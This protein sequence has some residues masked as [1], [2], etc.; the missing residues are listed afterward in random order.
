MLPSFFETMILS[1][2]DKFGDYS[3][4]RISSYFIL[5][6]IAISSLAFVTVDIVNLVTSYEQKKVYEIPF[7][8]IA[9]F[10]LILGHHLVLLGLKKASENK[11]T[12]MN[13]LM[14]VEIEK[15]H[16]TTLNQTLQEPV[17]TPE[18]QDTFSENIVQE[19]AEKKD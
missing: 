9:I 4:T 17:Q 6:L 3:H 14:N 1:L 15:L 10:G 5:I 18:Q 19:D 8:H 13:N 11:Q 7:E 12:E 16:P 2:K